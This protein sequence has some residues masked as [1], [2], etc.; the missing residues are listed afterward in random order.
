MILV[1]GRQYCYISSLYQ[2]LMVDFKFFNHIS[3]FID[4]IEFKNSWF[5]FDIKYLFFKLHG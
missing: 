4:K 2:L 3:N 5:Q 1:G